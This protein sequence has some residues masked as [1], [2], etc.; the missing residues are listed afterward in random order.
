[1]M[2][3]LLIFL[4]GIVVLVTTNAQTPLEIDPVVDVYPGDIEPSYQ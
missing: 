1:M 3:K 2:K 4:L